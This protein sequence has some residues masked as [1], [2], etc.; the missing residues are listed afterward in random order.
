MVP[1]EVKNGMNSNAMRRDKTLVTA[2]R[3]ERILTDMANESRRHVLGKDVLVPFRESAP[4]RSVRLYPEIFGCL[5][6]G[7]ANRGRAGSPNDPVL[8][9]YLA[10]HLMFLLQEVWDSN[11][12]HREWWIY[13]ARRDYSIWWCWRKEEDETLHPTLFGFRYHRWNLK[14]LQKAPPLSLDFKWLS[15]LTDPPENTPFDQVMRHFQ[16]MAPRARKCKNPSCEAPYF[17]AARRSQKYCSEPCAR[18]AQRAAKR[19]WWRKN[20]AKKPKRRKRR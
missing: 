13:A 15:P 16:R 5:T 17:F 8:A 2:R 20:R 3:A 4:V 11:P 7:R 1:L 10:M 9:R 14:D 18:P 12:R 19:K 6:P